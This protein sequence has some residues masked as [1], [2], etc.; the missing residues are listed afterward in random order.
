MLKDLHNAKG[1]APCK[2]KRVHTSLL[3]QIALNNTSGTLLLK[4]QAGHE[5]ISEKSAISA[6]NQTTLYFNCLISIT[7]IHVKKNGL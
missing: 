3:S 5:K 2:R 6:K 7:P 4:K 1:T